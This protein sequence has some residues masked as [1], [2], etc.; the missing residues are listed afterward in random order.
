MSSITKTIEPQRRNNDPLAIRP[1]ALQARPSKAG[2]FRAR[3]P[4]IIS[5]DDLMLVPAWGKAQAGLTSRLAP[6]C[7]F[8]WLNI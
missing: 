5:L 1:S 2:F 8:C 7:H 4:A 3:N 6:K